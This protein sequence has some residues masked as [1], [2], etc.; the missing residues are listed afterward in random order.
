MDPKYDAICGI[1]RD[2]LDSVLAESI[3]QIAEERNC[4]VEEVQ[5]GLERRYDGYHFSER[6]TDIYNPFSLLNAFSMMRIRDFWFATGTP[7]YLVKLLSHSK[8]DI[9]QLTGKYMGGARSTS[10]EQI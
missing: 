1:T 9:S 5:K 8:V 7:T 10:I 3:A 4:S 2:E 6:M